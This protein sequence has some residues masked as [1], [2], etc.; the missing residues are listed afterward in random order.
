MLKDYV[1]AADGRWVGIRCSKC[2]VVFV[3]PDRA[4]RHTE[5]TWEH[6]S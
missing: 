1:V 2:G 6:E 4:T 3:G 5:H